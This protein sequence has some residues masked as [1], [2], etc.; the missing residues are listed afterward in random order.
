MEE[1]SDVLVHVAYPSS[2]EARLLVRLA[3]AV[4]LHA[5]RI[6]F[7]PT[8]KSLPASIVDQDKIN[9][10]RQRAEVVINLCQKWARKRISSK[11]LKDTGADLLEEHLKIGIDEMSEYEKEASKLVVDLFWG[12]LKLDSRYLAQNATNEEDRHETFES[13]INDLSE[14]VEER[15]A[16]VAGDVSPNRDVEEEIQEIVD[17]ILGEE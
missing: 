8:A 10:C 13:A 14:I 2:D 16:D 4:V 1:G 3:C 5:V 6:V 15:A 12:T 7:D 9:L 17:S 11:R